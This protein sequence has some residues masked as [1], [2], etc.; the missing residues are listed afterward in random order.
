MP[1]ASSPFTPVAQCDE[2][3]S[4]SCTEDEALHVREPPARPRG[5][6]KVAVVATVTGLIA[7]AGTW[8][9]QS[10]TLGNDVG[11]EAAG[12]ATEWAAYGT[13]GCSNWASIEISRS[14][15]KDQAECATK[16][17]T[18]AGCTMYNWQQDACEP[19][20]PVAN[21]CLLFKESCNTERNDCWEL[22]YKLTAAEIT[23]TQDMGVTTPASKTEA[24]VEAAVAAALAAAHIK[25]VTVE[26]TKTRRLVGEGRNLA[27][28]SLWIVIWKFVTTSEAEGNNAYDYAVSLWSSKEIEGKFMV[29]A[30]KSLGAALVILGVSE[31]VKESG[32]TTETPGT[33][34]S[35]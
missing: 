5:V 12:L 4:T 28:V 18:T 1:A 8:W 30:S 32:G 23:V 15:V 22:N 27:D 7:A 6:W 10:E 35:E 31:P 17:D 20:W 24:E 13:I 29:A 21:G 9:S 34:E 25:P 14:Q 3:P 26:A 16:C 11:E 33:T 2:I 19:G